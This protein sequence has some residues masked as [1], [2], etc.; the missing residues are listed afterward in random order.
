[1]PETIQ[2]HTVTIYDE[3]FK[4]HVGNMEIGVLLN[5]SM[6][7]T[8]LCLSAIGGK[9]QRPPEWKKRAGS[10][11]CKEGAAGISVV[12]EVLD[13]E[14]VS[15]CALPPSSPGPSLTT[16]SSY[17]RPIVGYQVYR[18]LRPTLG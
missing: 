1:M 14:Q 13:G 6:Q 2:Y 9:P 8:D 18:Q 12:F 7:P 10:A 15:A 5:G 4:H 11:F 17:Y 16:T 3:T